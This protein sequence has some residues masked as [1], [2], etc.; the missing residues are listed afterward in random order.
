MYTVGSFDEV[1]NFEGIPDHSPGAPMP[2]ILA[3]DNNLL[4][5]YE[6]APGGEE[7]AIVKFI[8]PH[9]HYFG[10]PNDETIRGHP[11]AE[12]GLRPYGVFEIRNSSWTRALEQMNR[13]HPR[14]NASRFPT[15]RHFVFT[16]H[17]NTFECVAN[18]AQL[19]AQVP[20]DENAKKL[21]G[22]MASYLR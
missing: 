4:L 5:A 6:M 3:N 13:V 14:H 10:S 7:Y 17:D 18:D 12:R 19:A 1:I 15:L 16:F 2:Q 21:L 20:N 8:L 11:L 22:L 9:A